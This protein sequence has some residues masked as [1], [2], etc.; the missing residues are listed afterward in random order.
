M[1]WR[2]ADDGGEQHGEDTLLTTMP[3]LLFLR[4]AQSH[5]YV[6][7]YPHLVELSVAHLPHLFV[8]SFMISS[9]EA[10]QGTSPWSHAE[11]ILQQR[12]CTYASSSFAARPLRDPSRTCSAA[13]TP[14][15]PLAEG[16]KGC[17][18]A[19]AANR[20]HSLSMCTVPEVAASFAKIKDHVT[21]ALLSLE[22]LSHLAPPDLD[23]YKGLLVN[24]LPKLLTVQDR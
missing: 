13:L 19:A 2:L 6:P 9:L 3:T 4:E 11:I 14:S 16:M 23:D 20:A 7:L 24:L 12:A 5:G 15:I 22:L 10:S 17:Q 8:C 1:Y 18:G 21:P